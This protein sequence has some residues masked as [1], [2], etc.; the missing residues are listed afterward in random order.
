MFTDYNFLYNQRNEKEQTEIKG[1]EKFSQLK[2]NI[3][4]G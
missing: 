1:E 4:V 3:L 2:I